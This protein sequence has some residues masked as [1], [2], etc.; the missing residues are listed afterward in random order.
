M[1]TVVKGPQTLANVLGESLGK[2]TSQ[3]LEERQQ[4]RALQQQQNQ[5]QSLYQDLGLDPSIALLPENIQREVVKNAIKPSTWGEMLGEWLTGKPKAGRIG[6]IGTGAAQ[7]PSGPTLNVGGQQIPIQNLSEEAQQIIQQQTDLPQGETTWGQALSSLGVGGASTLAGI[8]GDIVNLLRSLPEA[9]GTFD[10]AKELRNV[11]KERRPEL[12]PLYE[13]EERRQEALRTAPLPTGENIRQQAIAPSV[14]GTP[15]EK[16][17]VPQTQNQKWWEDM[18]S[19]IS[20]LASPSKSGT[21]LAKNIAKAGS[22]ALGGDL[23]GFMTQ[24]ATGSKT[25]GDLVRNGI[26]LGYLLY[27]G[28]MGQI[29]NRKYK[30]FDNKVLAKAEKEGKLINTRPFQ[31]K[32]ENIAKKIDTQLVETSDAAKWARN[33]AAKVQDLFGFEGKI[34]PRALSNNIKEMNVR[35]ANAPKQAKPLMSEMINLQEDMLGN[36]ANRIIPNGGQLIKDAN[37]ISQAS[38]TAINELKKLSRITNPRSYGVALPLYFVGGYPAVL[39]VGGARAGQLYMSKMLKSPAMRRTFTQLMKASSRQQAQLANRLIEKL[40]TQG[41]KILKTLPAR[42]QQ[43]IR[44]AIN[45]QISKIA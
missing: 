38:T 16:F 39:G 7:E 24:K 22:V 18:G 30:E 31:S 20:I 40:N 14:K 36:F 5:L 17:L 28:G 10:R 45:E 42:D 34:N 26:Y 44:T 35:L 11:A 19:I 23:A 4:Q 12:A 25:A 29:A 27:P 41:E 8:P 6:A 1:V 33:E 13:A 37:D 43:N 2:G 3:F 32:F 9:M 15:L 21:Q